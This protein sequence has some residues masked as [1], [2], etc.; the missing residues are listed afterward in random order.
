MYERVKSRH[1][2]GTTSHL[3]FDSLT[4][5]AKH[6]LMRAISLLQLLGMFV[7]VLGMCDDI[8][9]NLG[10]GNFQSRKRFA[11]KHIFVYIMALC[12]NYYGMDRV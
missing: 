11:R 3:V 5:R 8:K 2:K 6:F 4:S 12:A 9:Y 10:N 7:F 1:T